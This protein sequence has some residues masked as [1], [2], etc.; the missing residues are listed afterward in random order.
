MQTVGYMDN[1]RGFFLKK[2]FWRGECRFKRNYIG[3]NSV[4][5][6]KIIYRKNDL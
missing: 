4:D 2:G 1:L 3:E 6:R 5:L